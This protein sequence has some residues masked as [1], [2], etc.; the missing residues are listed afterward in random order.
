[1]DELHQLITTFSET[2]QKE[3][4]QF[5][6]RNRRKNERKDLDLFNLL[7][8][9]RQSKPKNTHDQIYDNT[10]DRNAYHSLRKRLVKHLHDFIYVKQTENDDS[11]RSEIAK[12]LALVNVLFAHQL[13]PLAWKYLKRAEQLAESGE[14][15]HQLVLIYDLQITNYNPEHVNRSIDKL[16]SR[17][18]KASQF[19]EEEE[20]LRI[21]GSLVKQELEKVKLEG[22][23]IDL[24]KI[25]DRLF[26]RFDMDDSIFNRPR[27]LY[28]FVFLTRNVVLAKKT[29]YSFENFLLSSYKR[30]Q[31]SGFFENK[32]DEHLNMLYIVCHTLYRNRKFDLAIEYLDIMNKK[33]AEVSKG[34]FNRFNSR[35]LL[36]LAACKNFNRNLK[37][38]ISILEKLL[39]EGIKSNQDTLNTKLNLSMYYFQLKDF[40]KAH[41][42]II[43]LGHTDKWCEKIMGVE[44]VFKKNI[45]EVFFLYELE[46]TDIAFDRIVSI[47]RT[48]KDLFKTK[49]YQRVS[50][51][52]KLI[53]QIIDQP[54]DVHSKEFF[55]KVENSFEWVDI[56]QEDLQAVS[57]YAW[58]KSKMQKR[59]FYDVLLELLG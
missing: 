20:R 57:Y 37:E 15:N 51:F 38:S 26:V 34:L 28:D 52:L 3:F 46:K 29:F 44:W 11:L 43:N 50:V 21:I 18:L 36:L 16:V 14:L 25:I 56:E 2:E 31:K 40:K 8:E 47:E 5:I 41:R 58:L 48:Y 7:S 12:N 1:M 35:Y 32:N 19:A 17:R 27:L 9:N 33:L 4:R 54:T 55:E 42:T 22:K 45:I 49:K 53:K 23:D 6:Q 59:E 13:V 39:E 24:Q 10:A 30:V